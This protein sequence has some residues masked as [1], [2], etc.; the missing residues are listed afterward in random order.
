MKFNILDCTIRDGGYYNAWDFEKSL[1]DSYIES[2]NNLPIDYIEVGYRNNPQESYLG[3]YAYSPEYE[4]SNIR[5]KSTKKISIM[6]NEK[7]V[8]PSDLATLI[9]PIEKLVDIVR[10]A[11]DPISIERA[12][13]LAKAIKKFNVE[14]GFNVMYM[15]R[16]ESYEGL[17]D[18]FAL[19][20]D[21][22]DVLYMVDSF[23]AAL[24][25]EIAK[26]TAQMK[27]TIS[28]KIGFHGHNNL[29]LAL[30]NTLTAIENG[31]DFVDSTFMGMGRG[32][33]NL[34]TELALAYLNAHYGLEVDLNALAKAVGYFQKLR[35]KYNWGT[36]LPYMISGA[37]SFPQKEVMEWTTNRAY[38]F[39]SIVRALDNKKKN[40]TDNAK[41]PIFDVGA[42]ESVIIVGGGP[43]AK[44]H[45]DGVKEFIK[46]RK[47]NIAIIHSTSR[48]MIDYQDALAP[49]FL[50]LTGSEGDIL[51][52]T[53][54]SI[55]HSNGEGTSLRCRCVLPPH[56]RK[57]GTSVPDFIKEQ[58]FELASIDFTKGCAESCTAIALQT[59]ALLATKDIFVIGYDGYADAEL[60]SGRETELF[61]ENASLFSAFIAYHNRALISL[62]PTHY[63]Q[64]DVVSLYQ[65]I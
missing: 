55:F 44:I 10:V 61:K 60:S 6:L 24:P 65:N 27:Q 54:P 47:T 13:N 8:K 25:K 37:N 64:M 50:C 57:L 62:A 18:K 40:I 51:S 53:F 39:N 36:N 19:L 2:T 63:P 41:Y 45:S 4:L 14:V 42:F 31:V 7:D 46:K 32:A 1:I 49:Q 16:W 23:G 56:P 22:V 11:V 35:A 58:T 34:K 43:L 38:P 9:Q 5:N 26:I 52:Q 3:K 48:H 20:N 21:N 17:F 12:A 59:A 15:S 30:I 33:G 29:E 28:C